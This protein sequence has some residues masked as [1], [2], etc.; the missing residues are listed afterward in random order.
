MLIVDNLKKLLE[1]R[2]R[3]YLVLVA[4]LIA[5]IITINFLPIVGII[6][7][8]PFLAFV[9]FLFL[10]SVFSKKDIRDIAHWKVF[11]LL[12][13]SLPLMLIISVFL[14]ALFAFSIIS[15]M[16]MTSWFILYGLI[17]TSKK[18][19]SNLKER[20]GK[21]FTRT[22]EFL[23]GLAFSLVL[24]VLFY[25]APVIDVQKII[26]KNE[27]PYY[28]GI[29]LTVA[30][31]IVGAAIIGIGVLCFYYVFKKSF[32][33]WYGI[34]VVLAAGYTFYLVLKIFLA[35][36]SPESGSERSLLTEIA[37]L[38]ADVFIIVYAISTLLGKQAEILASKFKRFG[39]DT[40]FIWLL[41][42]KASYEFVVNFPYGDIYNL[43]IEIFGT[44]ASILTFFGSILNYLNEDY[45]TLAKN[46]AVLFFFLAL[47]V[48]LGLWEI[49]KYNRKQS[50]ASKEEMIKP[51]EKNLEE[52]E[53][54]EFP[55]QS[56]IETEE[57]I[58]GLDDNKEEEISIAEHLEEKDESNEHKDENEHK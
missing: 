30:Y 4:W 54:P 24:L 32:N 35:I 22:I 21:K 41:F 44:S 17:L 46:I 56:R 50:I 55:V 57:L 18:I 43:S 16:F 23:G 15:Y 3:R 2:N 11:L 29:Y 31:I 14:L 53:T 6:I 13:A 58:N 52:I 51:I 39:L 34:F 20:K 27:V 10:L 47:F 33:A 42:S 8:L 40:A 1:K 48:L 9:M 12:L 37:L 49:R 28:L 19:D 36:T 45:I 5:G 25:F 7:F 38:I 26:F